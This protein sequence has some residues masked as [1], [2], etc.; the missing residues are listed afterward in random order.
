MSPP[1]RCQMEYLINIFH[2]RFIYRNSIFH[3]GS[4][5]GAPKCV[6]TGFDF[7][8]NGETAATIDCYGT[9]TIS[10]VN[11]DSYRFHMDMVTEISYGEQHSFS[12][13]YQFSASLMFQHII[14]FYHICS[15]YHIYRS[16]F[17]S[18]HSHDHFL[19]E[20]SHCRF[21]TNPD[22]PLLFVKYDKIQLNILDIEKKDL[23]LKSPIQTETKCNWSSW[24]ISLFSLLI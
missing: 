3:V 15:S 20:N 18:F 10:D 11:T 5:E 14:L 4:L 23:I 24:L 17:N 19:D 8:L 1:T 21:S 16:Y 7:N 12:N 22:E 9:C 2:C 13:Q 6:I